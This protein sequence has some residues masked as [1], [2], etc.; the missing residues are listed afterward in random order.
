MY[1]L[2]ILCYFNEVSLILSGTLIK[3]FNFEFI[4]KIYM[5]FVY[6][7]YLCIT[8]FYIYVVTCYLYLFVM[9]VINL[10]VQASSSIFMT[11]FLLTLI[12]QPRLVVL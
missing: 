1:F 6:C 11:G 10:D 4:L 12:L 8:L 5:P 7:S 3:Y 2:F 9:N